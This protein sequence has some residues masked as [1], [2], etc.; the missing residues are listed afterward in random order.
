MNLIALFTFIGIAAVFALV[1]AYIFSRLRTIRIEGDA[2]NQIMAIYIFA[3]CSI[4]VAT[5]LLLIRF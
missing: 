2:A 1:N 5:L 4:V 3:A